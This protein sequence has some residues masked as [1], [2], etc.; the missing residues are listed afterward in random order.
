M[1]INNSTR[2]LR[3]LQPVV[4]APSASAPRPDRLELRHVSVSDKTTKVREI[5]L[6]GVDEE[7]LKTVATLADE[8]L[9]DDAEGVG[10]VQ[11]YA[12]EAR[13][14]DN[15]IARL[16]LRYK[17]EG[18]VAGEDSDFG[19]EPAT[20]SGLVAQAMRHAEAFARVFSVGAVSQIEALTRQNARLTSVIED[21][22]NK[23]IEMAG[24]MA[25]LADKKEEREEARAERA[26]RRETMEKI[27]DN[28]VP[29]IPSVTKLIT[30][31]TPDHAL[32]PEVLALR[33]LAG[34]LSDEQMATIAGVLSPE[35]LVTLQAV[36]EGTVQKQISEAESAT[37]NGAALARRDQQ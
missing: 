18:G 21:T 9:Y 34:N 2:L 24:T 19:S 6:D 17:A 20:A 25:D 31:A 33:G 29:L 22:L 37:K 11:R 16:V 5:P 30:G 14:G 3:W 10:G 35:Q 4:F 1:A 27:V 7:T 15:L 13:N 32:P 8:T 36:L 23:R 26:M 12:V 28:V